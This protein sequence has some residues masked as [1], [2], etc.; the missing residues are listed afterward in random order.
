MRIIIASYQARHGL[1]EGAEEVTEVEFIS[2][3]EGY[4]PGWERFVGIKMGNKVA[5]VKAD[6]LK[7]VVNLSI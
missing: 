7:R 6:E 2:E 1:I 4:K 3:A 5:L